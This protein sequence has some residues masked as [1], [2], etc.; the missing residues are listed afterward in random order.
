M[1]LRSGRSVPD[2][3][4]PGARLAGRSP[5]EEYGRLKG[6]SPWGR[7]CPSRKGGRDSPSRRGGRL[8]APGRAEPPGRPDPP[9]RAA[10]P[11]RRSKRPGPPAG[12]SPCGLRKGRSGR[13]PPASPL[14]KLRGG[15]SPSRAGR[16]GR[17]CPKRD[18]RAPDAGHLLL[19]GSAGDPCLRQSGRGVHQQA[20]R[21]G[22]HCQRA[23]VDG[24]CRSRRRICLWTRHIRDDLKFRN[25]LELRSVS[26]DP[27]CLSAT[28]HPDVRAFPKN[29]QSWGVRDARSSAGADGLLPLLLQHEGRHLR[30]DGRFHAPAWRNRCAAGAAEASFATRCTIAI[31]G[32]LRS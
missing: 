15:R 8:K 26:G 31:D 17:P 9:G 30:H 16:A 20:C 27:K 11:G 6:R 14:P 7:D 22:S 25:D 32:P 29:L 10:P 2:G 12:R 1:N 23:E 28:G 18:D 4:P 21:C 5:A 19:D 24:P 13:V 3:G